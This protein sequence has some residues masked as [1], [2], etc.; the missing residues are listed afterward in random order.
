MPNRI[1]KAI[2]HKKTSKLRKHIKPGSTS[3]KL[4]ILDEIVQTKYDNINSV[5]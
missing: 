5:I 3:K 1:K 2:Y 4:D